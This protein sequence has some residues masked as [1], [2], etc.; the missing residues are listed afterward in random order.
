M[1]FQYWWSNKT[2]IEQSYK[3][4]IQV[5][6]KSPQTFWDNVEVLLM[7]KLTN[8]KNYNTKRF[9][10]LNC[11]ARIWNIIWQKLVVLSEDAIVKYKV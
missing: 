5:R 6:L 2:V 8:L 10:A 11:I 9:N 7:L 1:S 4:N 3:E